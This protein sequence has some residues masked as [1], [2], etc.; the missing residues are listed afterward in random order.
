ME[1]TGGFELLLLLLL[2]ILMMLMML[3]MLLMMIISDFERLWCLFSTERA[4]V[5]CMRFW[6]A[7]VVACQWMVVVVV[8]ADD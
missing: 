3:M 7:A 4:G 2:M 8:F 5:V 6:F 1:Q